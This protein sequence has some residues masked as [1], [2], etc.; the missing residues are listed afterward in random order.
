[1]PSSDSQEHHTRTATPKKHNRRHPGKPSDDVTS[2]VESP[3]LSYTPRV[4]Q[5]SSRLV[6]EL[7]EAP[8]TARLLRYRRRHKHAFPDERYRN[9][10]LSA[11]PDNESADILDFEQEGGYRLDRDWL[12]DVAL[13]LQV[14]VKQTEPNWQHGIVLYSCLRSFLETHGKCQATIL[15]TGT[16]RGFSSIVMARALIDAKCA[17][18]IHTIDILSHSEPQLWNCLGDSGGPR[19]RAQLLRRW[20]H[21]TGHIVFHEG[22]SRSVLNRTHFDRVHFAFLDGQHT[23]GALERELVYLPPRQEPGDTIVVDDVS[24]PQFADLRDLVQDFAVT[25]GYCYRPLSSHPARTYAIL[26]RD[27]L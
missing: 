10:L 11:L 21:E 14:T 2:P 4:T 20:P 9:L 19:T 15:E 7:K 22:S 25:H 16:A 24:W 3:A 1:M 17:G 5:T 18:T 26:R 8:W 13:H 6:R 27:G 23:V 12:L